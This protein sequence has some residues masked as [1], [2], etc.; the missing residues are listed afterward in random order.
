MIQLDT[1]FLVD[2]LRESR[3]GPGPATAFLEEVQEQDLSISIHV[4]CELHAGAELSREPARERLAIQRVCGA[5]E[6]RY[7]DERFA[8][9]YGRLLALLQ[10]SGRAISTMDLLIATA[11][12]VDE[13]PLVTRNI[14]HFSRISG[15]KVLRY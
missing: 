7:P 8:P 12:L 4:L 10:S 2:V 11:A 9:L 14:D 5:L 3:K 15:L 1:I 13:A 6:V